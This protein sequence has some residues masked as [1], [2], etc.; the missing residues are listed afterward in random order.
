[1]KRIGLAA[2]LLLLTSQAQ[3]QVVSIHIDRVEPFA[4]GASFGLVGA[5]ERVIGTAKGELDPKDPAN[6]AIIG[7]DRAPR[8]AS[9]RVEYDT[10]LFLLRPMDAAKGNH[11][12]LFE[13]TNR[14]N[15]YALHT[16]NQL[17]V[18]PTGLIND[19]KTA[20][21]AG[22]GLL[23]RQGYTLAWTGWDPDVPRANNTLAIRIPALTG[24][25]QEIRDEFVSGT[26]G[27]AMTQFRLSY[28][29][30]APFQGRLTVQRREA[31]TPTPLADAQWRFV[32]DRTLE[33]LPSGTAPEPGSIYSFVYRATD[34]WVSGIGLAVTRDVGA[35]LRAGGDSP[36]RGI[37]RSLAFGS[38]QSGRYLRNYLDDGF[39]RDLSGRRVFDGVL[40]HISGIGKVF[41]NTLYAQPGRTRTQH[42]DHF[43][44]ENWPPFST[45]T[46]TDPATGRTGSL[47]KGNVTDPLLIETNTSSEYWQKG[48]SLLSA[49][50]NGSLDLALPD[51]TRLYLIAGTQHGGRIGATTAP[52]PCAN[53]RNWHNPGPALRAVLAALDRWVA[54]GVPPP[55]SLV[56]RVADHT[57]VPAAALAFP[58]LPGLT[59]PAAADAITPRNGPDGDWVSPVRAASPY[60]ALVPMVDQDGNEVAGLRLPDQSVPIATLTGW[61]FYAAPF[62]TGE[63][64]D[65]DGSSLPFPTTSAERVAKG[66]PRLSLAERYGT[67]D[68]FVA[69]VKAAAEALAAQRLLLA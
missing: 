7:L 52:G 37:T 21:D 50:A 57:L 6:A 45:A 66:D 30:A 60:Q 18:P 63:M 56:P 46:V 19:P 58:A 28:R 36:A 23:L 27:P 69:R 29:A 10:D 65:R 33:L 43:M 51:S 25:T 41:L 5:Y 1:M 12:L 40:A 34:P 39:N 24:V 48:A 22:D 32:N 54:E 55:P 53:P 16:F 4:D 20:A 38:S 8:N 49:T 15:K 17:P 3:A 26:R 59:G 9:G 42:E 14:G 31:D 2:A 13:V 62:P 61:N 47:L 64:C 44:P 11:A 67:P 35:Y 68:L